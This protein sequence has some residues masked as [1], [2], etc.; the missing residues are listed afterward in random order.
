MHNSEPEDA[1]RRRVEFSISAKEAKIQAADATTN[2][3][4]EPRRAAYWNM[5]PLRGEGKR[6]RAN[7]EEKL[8]GISRIATYANRSSKP[9][10]Y[11]HTDQELQANQRQAAPSTER[12]S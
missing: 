7:P 8:N 3:Y 5:K 12:R 2:N 9:V 11:T 10:S 4:N 6:R 1:A